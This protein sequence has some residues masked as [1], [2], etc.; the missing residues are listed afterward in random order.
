M[1]RV[2]YLVRLL[3]STILILLLGAAEVAA[4]GTTALF[5]Q[6]QAGDYIGGGQTRTYT[7]ADGTFTIGSSTSAVT[8]RVLGPSFSFW[9]DFNFSA[10]AGAPLVP[11]VYNT[12]RRYPFTAFNGLSF[13]GSGAGCNTLTGRFVVLEAVYGSGG[14]VLKFAADFEQ[15]CE[16]ADAGLFGAIRFHSDVP[17]LSP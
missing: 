7:P 9:W 16:D 14:T 5:F 11:G 1:G 6:S 8:G 15:H 13:S 3:P 17:S 4:Q 10:P 12:A 2:R